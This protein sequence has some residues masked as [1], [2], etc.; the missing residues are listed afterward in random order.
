[1]P[2]QGV[3][4]KM[5]LWGVYEARNVVKAMVYDKFPEAAQKFAEER[6]SRLANEQISQWKKKGIR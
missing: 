5:Q 6:I 2:L 3:Q 4:A 1:M